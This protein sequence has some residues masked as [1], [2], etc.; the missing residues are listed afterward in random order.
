M[1]SLSNE[2]CWSASE[3]QFLS[4][5]FSVKLNEH[6]PLFFRLNSENVLIK[7]D[8]KSKMPTNGQTVYRERWKVFSENKRLLERSVNEK[9]FGSLIYLAY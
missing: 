9:C 8:D 6:D 2:P 3:L 4:I 5:A 1:D 7:L